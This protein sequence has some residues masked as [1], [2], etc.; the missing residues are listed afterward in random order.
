M[1]TSVPRFRTWPTCLWKRTQQPSTNAPI[2]AVMPSS[3]DATL[4]RSSARARYPVSCRAMQPFPS[5]QF[6]KLAV[7][8]CDASSKSR[9]QWFRS[10]NAS[11]PLSMPARSRWLRAYRSQLRP[12]R[13]LLERRFFLCWYRPG[14]FPGIVDRPLPGRSSLAAFTVGRVCPV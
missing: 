14:C 7:P 8:L 9:T 1:A 13:S 6:C 12:R 10:I 11:V 2:H 5:T 4:R 3:G